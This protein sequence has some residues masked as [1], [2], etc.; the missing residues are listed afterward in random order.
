MVE[1]GQ[2]AFAAAPGLADAFAWFAATPA[3]RLP[4]DLR[5]APV[6]LPLSP[7][8]AIFQP[9]RVRPLAD[10]EREAVDHALRAFGGNVARAARALQVNPSTLYRKIQVW[11]AQGSLTQ[12]ANP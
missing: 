9:G 6:S 12:G 2:A 1:P 8:A 5:Q 11:T 10:I 7:P 4:P 3:N